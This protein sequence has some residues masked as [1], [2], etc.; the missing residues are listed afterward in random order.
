MSCPVPGHDDRHPSAVVG[1]LDDGGVWV[2]CYSRCGTK[3]PWHALK[4]LGFIE[5]KAYKKAKFREAEC[6]KKLTGHWIYRWT[7][8]SPHSQTKRFDLTAPDGTPAGK[9]FLRLNAEGKNPG[10]GFKYILLYLPEITPAA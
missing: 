10:P 3:A 7:D 5:Q 6:E 2:K 8:G 1:D 9:K 4:D